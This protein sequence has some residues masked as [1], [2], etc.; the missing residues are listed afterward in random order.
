MYGNCT[1]EPSVLKKLIAHTKIVTLH[2]AAL[3]LR[4]LHLTYRGVAMIFFCQIYPSLS[5]LP[6][7]FH[8][9]NLHFF[10]LISMVKLY[11]NEWTGNL[12]VIYVYSPSLGGTER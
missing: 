12:S 3:G 5:V 10:F 11:T 7:H 6:Y 2:A 9:P 4:D 1:H 8:I